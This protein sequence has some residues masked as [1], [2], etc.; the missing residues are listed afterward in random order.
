MPKSNDA[1]AVTDNNEAAAPKSARR[2]KLLVF[3]IIAVALLLSSVPDIHGWL[4]SGRD[5]HYVG[6]S[7]NIDDCYVYM[8]WARQAAD[9]QFFARNLFTTDHQL[10][11][12]FNLYFLLI[13]NVA[14]LLHAP[15]LAV[16]YAFRIAG[17]A[18]L[19]WAVYRLAAWALPGPANARVTALAL[20]GLGAGFGWLY[21]SPSMMRNRLLLPVDTWQPEAITFMSLQMSSLFVVSTALIVLCM[22]FLIRSQRQSSMRDSVFAG[23]CALVLGNI[24]SYDILHIAGAWGLYLVV[25][26]I[27]ARRIDWAA[28]GRAVVAGLICTPTV[29]YQYLLYKYDPVFHARVETTTLSFGLHTYLLGYGLAFI[30]AAAAAI[31]AARSVRFRAMWRDPEAP[32]ILVCWVVAAFVIVYLPT[33]FQR[34]MIMGVHV[35]MGILAGAGVAYLGEWIGRKTK[36]VSAGLICL[37]VVLLSVPSNLTWIA[38]EYKHLNLGDSETNSTSFLSDDDLDI[39]DWIRTQTKATDAFVGIPTR[40]LFVPG[41]CD[42]KVWSGHWSETPDYPGK[43]HILYA[44]ERGM[45]PDPQAFLRETRATYLIWPNLPPGA[46]A[47]PYLTRVYGNGT[48][49]IYAIH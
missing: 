5:H 17:G 22:A 25:A 38:R 23:L 31:L 36:E 10:G 27:I 45:M 18:A 2:E 3:A 20:V 34:K 14:R 37:V 6:Y 15:L 29:I 40:M 39:Y 12:Q 13:G 35:P 4:L 41:L 47:P 7:Y 26:S 24:H 49:T 21:S 9:G 43:M 16:F 42:R 33:S 28:W 8:S 19:L 30:F 46:I 1:Q 11:R 48:Y 44:F 32:L